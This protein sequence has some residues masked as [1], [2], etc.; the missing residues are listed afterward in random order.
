MLKNEFRD[1]PTFAAIR[2]RRIVRRFS[3][4]EV[5]KLLLFELLELSNITPSAFNL[6]PWHFIIV[7]NEQLKKLLYHLAMRQRQVREAPVVVV[8]AADSTAWQSSYDKVLSL[9][10]DRRVISDK[11]AVFFRKT[12][13]LLFRLNPCGV[14]GFFKRFAAPLVRLFEPTPQLMTSR[15]ECLAYVKSQTMLAVSTFLT[16]AHA[17][18]LKTALVEAFDEER[19]AK[20]LA[21]P[22]S[23]TVASIVCLGYSREDEHGLTPV[24]L[25]LQEKLSLDIF[26]NKLDLEKIARKTQ[27]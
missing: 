27:H 12:V 21:M 6:Q 22:K 17:A 3:R 24:T 19:V 4:R 2:E 20:L 14:F 13:N 11:Q 16:A 9:S 5:S 25:E 18:G 1:N 15:A 8:F 7:R 10:R 26:N 23:M